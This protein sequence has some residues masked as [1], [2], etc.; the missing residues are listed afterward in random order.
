MLLVFS[1]SCD[2]ASDGDADADTDVDGDADIDGDADSDVDADA[3]SD[4]DQDADSDGDADADMDMDV[5]VDSADDA[6]SDADSEADADTEGACERDEDCVTGE[7]WCEGGRCEPC[8]DV[9]ERCTNECLE[10]WDHYERN[11]C[12]TCTCAPMNECTSDSGCRGADQHCYAGALC[13]DWCVPA[14]PGCCFGN[15][16]ATSG[17]SESPS[18]GC[19]VRG[20]PLGE[21][22]VEEAG[23]TPGGG[24]CIDGV[25]SLDGDCGGGLCVEEGT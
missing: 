5:D 19:L 1:S 22:C 7:E 15:I 20:C 11:G 3:D 23:C 18:F 12:R 25:W 2:R 4:D 24:E 8:V 14:E 6:D 9:G 10:G 17:C 13:W 16:C 21:T